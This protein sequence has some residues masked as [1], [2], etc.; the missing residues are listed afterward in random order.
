MWLL[1]A[2]PGARVEGAV[3]RDAWAVTRT[4]L[5]R[6][7]S[8]EVCQSSFS[9]RTGVALAHGFISVSIKPTEI[10]MYVHQRHA[11]ECSQRL[12]S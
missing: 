7:H 12:Y 4:P 11:Q 2:S 8:A 5:T 6:I 9:S 10:R 3:P 1:P